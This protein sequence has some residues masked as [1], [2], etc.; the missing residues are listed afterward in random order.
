MPADKP[1]TFEEH[2]KATAEDCD[3]FA[4][5]VAGVAKSVR[6]GNMKAFETFFLEGGTEEGDAK[7]LELRE[8]ILLR[9]C[10]RHDNL[11]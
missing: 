6:E 3:A 11:K 7:M 4:A 9:Y 5:M 1:I 8:R 10:V 2:K